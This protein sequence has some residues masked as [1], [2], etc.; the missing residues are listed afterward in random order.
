[1]ATG[2]SGVEGASPPAFETS[3]DAQ[4]ARRWLARAEDVAAA[5]AEAITER[6]EKGGGPRWDR[7]L[8]SVL[9]LD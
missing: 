7:P 1:V 5:A 6:E 3:A 4:A 8:C 9:P 2:F